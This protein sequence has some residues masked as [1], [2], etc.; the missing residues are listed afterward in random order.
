MKER[1][2]PC[3]LTRRHFNL[4]HPEGD[5]PAAMSAEEDESSPGPR[6]LRGLLGCQVSRPWITPMS[7]LSA[8]WKT[9]QPPCLSCFEMGLQLRVAHSD[10]RSDFFRPRS[11]SGNQRPD[12][13]TVHQLLPL[14]CPEGQKQP[15][16][17][18]SAAQG[19]LPG[20]GVSWGLPRGRRP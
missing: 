18:R 13:L 14:S 1:E 16:P 3:L 20:R 9:R 10:T 7:D 2:P 17:E 19:L 4:A 6:G 11:R 12:L 5:R 8:V 15:G